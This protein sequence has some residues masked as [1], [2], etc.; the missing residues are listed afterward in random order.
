MN[1]INEK[2]LAFEWLQNLPLSGI[3]LHHATV[4]L[5]EIVRLNNSI[6]IYRTETPLSE[7]ELEKRIIKLES[8]LREVCEGLV[9]V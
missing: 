5:K 8:E 6:E 7:L 4:L 9:S 1:N 2:S 3:E